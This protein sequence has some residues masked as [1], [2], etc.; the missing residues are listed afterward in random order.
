[1]YRHWLLFREEVN[2]CGAGDM[3]LE[4]VIGIDAA[5]LAETEI[6]LSNQDNQL[7]FD[8]FA[9]HD[10]A[11]IFA[12]DNLV[13]I[14]LCVPRNGVYTVTVRD[15]AGDGWT[16][17]FIEIYVDRDLVYTI[18]GNFGNFLTV[19]IF[20]QT[21]APT[22]APTI[23]ATPS[24]TSVP[25][26]VPEEPTLVP[27]GSMSSTSP[28]VAPTPESSDPTSEIPSSSEPTSVPSAGNLTSISMWIFVIFI[29]LLPSW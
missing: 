2:T 29:L 27:A 7:Y 6:L 3:E 23:P 21:I 19:D 11:Y 28:T 16:D 4:L 13:L 25:T 26:G 10:L 1:M 8:S 15:S 17:G 12:T 18:N 9:D 14:D 24:P 22:N 5:Y 20:Q